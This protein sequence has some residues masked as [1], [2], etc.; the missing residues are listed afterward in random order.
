MV[1]ALLSIT[2]CYIGQED[3]LDAVAIAASQG[4][5]RPQTV[6]DTAGAGALHTRYA[7]A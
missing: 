7:A 3:C 1:P 4:K 5:M 6:G 2:S